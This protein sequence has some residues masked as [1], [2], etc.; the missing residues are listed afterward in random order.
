LDLIGKVKTAELTVDEFARVKLPCDYVDWVRVGTVYGQNIL[1]MG[2]T[3]TFARN[4][5]LSDGVYTPYSDA[6]QTSSYYWA[7]IYVQDWLDKNGDFR[8]RGFGGNGTKTDTFMVIGDDIMQLNN[9]YASG[10][11]IN[12]DYIAFDQHSASSYVHKYAESTIRA[13]MEYMYLC[14]LPKTQPYDKNVAMR[15]Y[16]DE[17]RKLVARINPLD[18]EAISRIKHRRFSQS[19]KF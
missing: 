7:S 5:K 14:S 4:L 13:Y 17:H 15:T 2:E 19:V 16:Q 8:G 6:E 18:I 1:K 10:D 11:I 12:L 3:T 9:D